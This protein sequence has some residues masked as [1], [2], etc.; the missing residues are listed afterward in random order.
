MHPAPN[1]IDQDAIDRIADLRARYV[2]RRVRL[3]ANADTHHRG[4][5]AAARELAEVD[6]DIFYF[7]RAIEA[8][9]G[10]VP[11]AEHE[12]IERVARTASMPVHLR[13]VA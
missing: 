10:T 12:A 1:P 11:E 4:P 7:R 5:I 13:R 9:G 8:L 6:A 3:A 2:A